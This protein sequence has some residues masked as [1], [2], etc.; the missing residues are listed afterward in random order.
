VAERQLQRMTVDEWRALERSSEIRHE[1]LDG[2]VYALAGGS[3]AHSAIAANAIKALNTAFGSGPCFACTFDLATRMLA[4][5]YTF[6]DVVV[7][8][9]CGDEGVAKRGE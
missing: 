4:G 7:A 6:A 1:Y 9:E 8:C 2:Y 5:H 3:Q